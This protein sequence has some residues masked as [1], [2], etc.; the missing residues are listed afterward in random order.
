MREGGVLM[1]KILDFIKRTWE[2][3]QTG[4]ARMEA[5]KKAYDHE[6]EDL[7]SYKGTTF[8]APK[9]MSNDEYQAM[10]QKEMQHWEDKYDLSTVR[11]INSIPVPRRKT[12]SSGTGS[13]TGQIDYY[14]MMK[15]G[16]YETSGEV[17]LALACYRKANELM[18]MCDIS[19]HTKDRYM[20]LPRYLR[21]LRRFDEARE[22][23]A[24]I[25]KLFYSG[26]VLSGAD[27]A[28]YQK[29][30]AAELR[31]AEKEGSDLVEVSWTSGCCETCGKYRGRIFS[32]KGK[33]SR[34]PKFPSD[35]CEKCGLTYFPIFDFSIPQHSQKRGKAL[36]REMNKPFV[37][38]RTK[39]DIQNYQI[40]LSRIKE[41][42]ERELRRADYDWIW[43]FMPD[44]CPK[45]FSGYMRMKN[46]N[47]SKYQQLAD[48]A[49][50]HGR[51]LR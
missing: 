45:S 26:S 48:E 17:E 44:V 24:K 25:K 42:A 27:E 31:W 35:F 11:G 37:D 6:G 43:E 16:Q 15:A 3:N 10:R 1:G 28:H 29:S 38:T 14:L 4:Y 5:T 13:V 19:S 34:F 9:P 40:R 39:E 2:E 36:I 30:K 21:K 22:E 50:K 18:P 51:I 49:K 23:E 20:R 12:D 33:D 8:W 47:T 46:A 7:V 32:M 41:E